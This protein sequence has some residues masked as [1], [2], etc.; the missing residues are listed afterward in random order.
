MAGHCQSICDHIVFLPNLGT[1]GYEWGALL[2]VSYSGLA[3][4]NWFMWDNLG[5]MNTPLLCHHEALGLQLAVSPSGLKGWRTTEHGGLGSLYGVSKLSGLNG[6][7]PKYF[8]SKKNI[9]SY[10]G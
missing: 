8:P 2:L 6:L 10:T 4:S 1:S 9:W 7:T 5:D 3:S